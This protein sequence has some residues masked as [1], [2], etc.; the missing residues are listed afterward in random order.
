MKD[1]TFDNNA[2]WNELVLLSDDAMTNVPLPV[3]D[4]KNHHITLLLLHIRIVGFRKL[5]G[6][7]HNTITNY[8][9]VT[10][11]KNY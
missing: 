4:R 3:K 11:T 2:E 1:H 5:H 9:Q 8:Y 10:N 7:F 6:T